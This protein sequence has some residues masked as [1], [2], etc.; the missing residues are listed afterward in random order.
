MATLTRVMRV[1]GVV[2]VCLTLVVLLPACESTG[3]YDNGNGDGAM[4]SATCGLEGCDRAADAGISAMVDGKKASFCG[5]G[6]K[7]SA[8]SN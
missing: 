6:C 4:A 1:L 7:A 2:A 5:A 8:L 3:Y